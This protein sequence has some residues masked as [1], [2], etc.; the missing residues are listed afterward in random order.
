[1]K[2]DKI[3]IATIKSWNLENVWKIL[4]WS[5]IQNLYILNPIHNK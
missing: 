5:F 1:M 2:M 4:F 3:I